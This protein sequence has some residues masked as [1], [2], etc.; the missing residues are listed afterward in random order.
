MPVRH[1][2]AVQAGSKAMAAFSRLHQDL[3]TADRHIT[4]MNARQQIVRELSRGPGKR[5]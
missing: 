3:A 1:H 2:T 5:S 4:V